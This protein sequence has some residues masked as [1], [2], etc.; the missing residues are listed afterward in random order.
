MTF[1]CLI[2]SLG[3]GMIIGSL[4]GWWTWG[5]PLRALLIALR[6]VV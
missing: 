1:D 4:L 2:W 6:E 5:R 3:A